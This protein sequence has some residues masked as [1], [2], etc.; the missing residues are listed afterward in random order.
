MSLRAACAT[1]AASPTSARPSRSARNISIRQSV[2]RSCDL[3][4]AC[5]ERSRYSPASSKSAQLNW[6][7]A[8]ARNAGASGAVSSHPWLT[9]IRVAAWPKPA[10]SRSAPP[11]AL[12]S[13]S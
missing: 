10:A 12:N 5:N 4:L 6:T 2:V 11:S 13:A 1:L 7:M 8:K 9:A 3:P